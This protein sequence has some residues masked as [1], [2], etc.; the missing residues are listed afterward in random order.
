MCQ[1]LENVFGASDSPL[2]ATPDFLAYIVCNIAVVR[3]CRGIIVPRYRAT[4]KERGLI[5]HV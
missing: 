1:G 4:G 5:V 3:L 2:T